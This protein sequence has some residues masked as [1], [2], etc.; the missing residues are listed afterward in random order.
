MKAMQHNS[1]QQLD[2]TKHVQNIQS[3]QDT[4]ALARAHADAQQSKQHEHEMEIEQQKLQAL[5]EST[6]EAPGGRQ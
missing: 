5:R 2:A 1:G 3:N 6:V 4:A